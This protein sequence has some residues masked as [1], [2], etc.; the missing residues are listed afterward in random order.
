MVLRRS[1]APACCVKQHAD[2]QPLGMCLCRRQR[3]AEAAEERSIQEY[4]R[5]RRE[6]EAQD[7]ARQA[8]KRE[9]QDRWVLPADGW[10][11][12]RLWLFVWAGSGE[13]GQAGTGKLCMCLTAC[14]PS[15]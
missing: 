14:G 7:A 11:A 1:R 5:R 9:A 3:E 13:Q 15:R 2:W 10:K 12:T 8:T 4:L 6:R